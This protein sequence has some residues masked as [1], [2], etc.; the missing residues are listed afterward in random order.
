MIKSIESEDDV[1]LLYAQMSELYGE[2]SHIS[3]SLL[4]TLAGIYPEFF[5][6][7]KNK[8]GELC[9]HLIALPLN[10]NGHHKMTDDTTFEAD[11]TSQDFVL[12]PEGSEE[13][14]LFIYSIYGQSDFQSVKMIR[15]LYQGIANLGHQVHPDS[16]LFAECVSDKGRRISERMG[17]SRYYSYVFDGEELLLY[18]SSL[19]HFLSYNSSRSSL[20]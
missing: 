4:V 14:F 8:F 9:S 1:R 12:A 18:R 19:G 13:V 6:L 3:S 11:F 7:G 17:L 5:L 16:L 20:S 2:Q 15:A 10:K